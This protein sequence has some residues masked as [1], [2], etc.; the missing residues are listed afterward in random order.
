MVLLIFV[1][2]VTVE[3]TILIN[4]SG[5]TSMQLTTFYLF[6]AICQRLYLHF[7]KKKF[8]S[9]HLLFR[10]QPSWLENFRTMVLA[11]LALKNVYYNIN[12]GMI[13][14]SL[15]NGENSTKY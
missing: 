4:T 9:S 3:R 10:I 14:P 8:F 6:F 7:S 12:Q 5:G 15:Y 1:H 2:S 11:I 13:K